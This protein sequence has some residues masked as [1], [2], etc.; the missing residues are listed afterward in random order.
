MRE[1]DGLFCILV[2]L[3]RFGQQTKGVFTPPAFLRK[4][5]ETRNAM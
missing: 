5:S 2:L 3:R 1:V 4:V